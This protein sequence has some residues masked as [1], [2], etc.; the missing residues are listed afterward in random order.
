MII[1]TALIAEGF[2]PQQLSALL[3]SSLLWH[4][5]SGVLRGLAIGVVSSL[6][7]VAGGELIIP[8]FVFAFGADI[9]TAGTASLLVSLPTVLVGIVRYTGR[10]A[11]AER[12]EVVEITVPMGGGSVLGAVL[13]GMLVGFVPAAALK[14]V[15]AMIL[16]LP[17]GVLL[18]RAT[19]GAEV[20]GGG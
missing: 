5:G 3:P 20:A 10:G 4:V 13:G 15:L 17:P 16:I 11:Y 8:T 19:A 2:L 1:G 18:R 9:K 7:G 6:L 12:R 14:V